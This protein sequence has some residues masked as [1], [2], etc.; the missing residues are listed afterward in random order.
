M[1]ALE[2]AP[3]SFVTSLAAAVISDLV[4]AMPELID[5]RRA[6][7]ASYCWPRA[8]MRLCA[9]DSSD[10]M[11]AALA[12]ALETESPAAG[13]ERRTTVLEHTVTRVITGTDTR[14]SSRELRADL[15][16]EWLRRRSTS[17]T[18]GDILTARA[19]PIQTPPG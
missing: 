17:V 2:S 19:R 12:R 15:G 18:M 8:D 3:R 6:C 14:R 7:A 16:V 13:R 5:W 1:A 11:A 4:L 10:S 9:A